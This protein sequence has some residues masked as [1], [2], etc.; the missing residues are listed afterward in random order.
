MSDPE[1]ESVEAFVAHLLDNDRE[2]F[3][4]EEAELL[5]KNLGRPA[6]EAI[7]A[8]KDYGLQMTPRAEP[9]RV[10]GFRTSSHDRWYGPGSS[11]THGGSGWEQI[12]G[13]GGQEG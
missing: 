3:S 6:S 11:P 12:A 8:L 13:F 2:D 10:R 4:F 9:K 7:R 1:F 5:G